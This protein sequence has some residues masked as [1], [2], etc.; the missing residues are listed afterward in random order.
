MFPSTGHER[1]LDKLKARIDVVREGLVSNPLDVDL[2]TTIGELMLEVR[3]LLF[4]GKWINPLPSNHWL[5]IRNF[6]LSFNGIAASARKKNRSL[7]FTAQRS[8]FVILGYI[9]HH[10]QYSELCDKW[11]STNEDNIF[12]VIQTMFS[13]AERQNYEPCLFGDLY[14]EGEW[15]SDVMG[16]RTL[17]LRKSLNQKGLSS[18]LNLW[19]SLISYS[20]KSNPDRIPKLFNNIKQSATNNYSHLQT[21]LMLSENLTFWRWIK[22]FNDIKPRIS[23][24]SEYEDALRVLNGEVVVGDWA[25]FNG[26]FEDGSQFMSGTLPEVEDVWPVCIQGSVFDSIAYMYGVCA[27]N[28]LWKELRECWYL[29]QPEDADANYCDHQLFS[30]NP[31]AFSGWINDHI[32]PLD[33]AIEERHDLKVHMA[34]ACT[35]LI[36]DMLNTGC[37]FSFRFDAI[38]NA[39]ELERF[40]TIL[41]TKS[42]FIEKE[43][44][45]TAF[46]WN[47]SEANTLKLN[48]DNFLDSEL[49]RCKQ[50]ITDSLKKCIPDTVINSVNMNFN[51][52]DRELVYE[53]W[54][55]TNQNFWKLFSGVPA[56]RVSFSKNLLPNIIQHPFEAHKSYYLSERSGKKLHALDFGGTNVAYRLIDKIAQTLKA[57]ASSPI[58]K[59]AEGSAWFISNDDWN[60]EGWSQLHAKYGFNINFDKAIRV[61]GDQSFVLEKDAAELLLHEWTFMPWSEEEEGCPVVV[62]GF[63]EFS[64][65][66]TGVSSLYYDFNILN[67]FGVHYL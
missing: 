42:G 34:A 32:I 43:P 20:A 53:A 48:V 7:N 67:P 31:D 17:S 58:T 13:E 62:Y 22:K 30:R 39:E 47:V 64:E 49:V 51:K 6:I 36:G 52:G 11:S 41:K 57:I 56:I 28:N 1:Y 33:R 66:T 60:E 4:D 3:S 21:P 26:N 12:D 65:C 63:T 55:Q 38:T 2:E 35:V 29:S 18:A 59:V 16:F 46:H 9:F 45:M 24:V 54:N 27:F 23:T 19:E 50:Y 14:A 25:V 8:V 10:P 37:S 15:V 40:I 44:V 5:V 61:S